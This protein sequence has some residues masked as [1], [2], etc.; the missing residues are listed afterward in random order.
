MINVTG[1]NTISKKISNVSSGKT[2][3]VRVRAYK[4]AGSSK[5][6][7]NWSAVKKVKIK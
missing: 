1:N 5:I 4:T 2:Y 3:Y 7:G 6:Y